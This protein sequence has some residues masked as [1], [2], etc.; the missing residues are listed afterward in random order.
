MEKLCEGYSL[1]EGPVWDADRGLI[2]S[3]LFNGGVFA[4]TPDGEV[5]VVF[6]HRRGIGGMAPHASGGLV[7]SGRNISY[8][9]FVGDDTV[10]LLDRDEDAGNIGYNDLTTDAA[11][12][13]YAGSLGPGF[14]GD[15]QPQPGDLYLIDLDGSSRKVAGDLHLTNGLAFSPDGKTLYHSDSGKQTIHCY[16]VLED[17]SLGDK[18][19]FAV[20]DRTPDG[21]AVSEDG[22]V[23]VAL[24][25]DG[26][27]GVFDPHGELL[28]V[29]EIPAPLCTS[30]CFG[31]DDM[32]DLYIVSGSE[33]PGKGND[34]AVF[35]QR[36]DVAGQAVPLARVTLP[37]PD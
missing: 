24:A 11:G 13:I 9:A 29:I 28:E 8:K 25:Y 36:V 3:D 15:F 34:G 10:M 4:V 7:V 12:R 26:G 14:D 18:Q 5:S 6:E 23:W 17:G 19:V 21:M 16:V 35:R 27:V 37:G 33:G 22:R 32:R 2:F 1:I 31:G 30:V 20:D